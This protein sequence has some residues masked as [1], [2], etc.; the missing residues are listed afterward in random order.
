[1]DG[2]DPEKDHGPQPL[3]VRHR[4]RPFS[5]P[6]RTPL[7]LETNR[8]LQT[9]APK[10]RPALVPGSSVLV[11]RPFL[12][13]GP[14]LVPCPWCVEECIK[15]QARAEYRGLRTENGPESKDGPRT[16]NQ[17]PRTR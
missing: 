9:P 8:Y 16:K 15:T 10:A 14:F 12:V 2:G 5:L 4:R 13:L 11:P 17:E 6:I 7:L 1:L 3:D